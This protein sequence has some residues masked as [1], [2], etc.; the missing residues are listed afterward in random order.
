MTSFLTANDQ[1]IYRQAHLE[2]LIDNQNA[3]MESAFE[4]ARRLVESVLGT[5]VT[6][7]MS[8]HKQKVK[9][10]ASG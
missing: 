8:N 7:V 10:V 6:V 2:I 3:S 9:D 4:S 5:K 1:Q